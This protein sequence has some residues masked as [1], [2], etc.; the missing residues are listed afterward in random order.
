MQWSTI[1]YILQMKVH[2]YSSVLERMHN[3]FHL[4]SPWEIMPISNAILSDESLSEALELL[5]PLPCIYWLR[6]KTWHLCLHGMRAKWRQRQRDNRTFA[7]IST[8]ATLSVL[9]ACPSKVRNDFSCGVGYKKLYEVTFPFGDH[10]RNILDFFL[11]N[12]NQC[13]GW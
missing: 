13:L 6:C 7:W 1:D 12:G 9:L 4:W 11:I 3:H 8:A 2:K 5:M 10:F